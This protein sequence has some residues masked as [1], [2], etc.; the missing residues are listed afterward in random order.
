MIVLSEREGGNPESGGDGGGSGSAL[1]EVFAVTR[2]AAHH[3]RRAVPSA[4]GNNCS[5]SPLSAKYKYGLSANLENRERERERER[6][7][8][9]VRY[10]RNIDADYKSFTM[11]NNKICY[12]PLC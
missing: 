12:Y 7:N 4:P 3:L 8:S 2:H 6:E 5:I 11:A 1:A 9:Q 10:T